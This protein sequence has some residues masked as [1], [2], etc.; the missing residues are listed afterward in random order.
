LTPDQTA[1]IKKAQESL[2]AAKLLAKDELYDFAASRA[3]YAM[4]YIAE[5]FLLEEGAAYSK[6]SAVISA[7]GQKFAKT[8][9]VPQPFHRYLIEGQE[10]RNIGDYDTGPG[11]SD[12]QAAEQISRAQQFIELAKRS[13]PV[14]RPH[15]RRK[16]SKRS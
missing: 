11:L 14:G 8:G 15:A 9:R 13:L 6:H 12:E 1:L 2:R 16:S 3:Y 10:I 4:F 7:F 5:A